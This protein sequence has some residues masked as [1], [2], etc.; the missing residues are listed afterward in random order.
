[1]HRL[2]DEPTG[3]GTVVRQQVGSRLAQDVSAPTMPVPGRG[4]TDRSSIGYRCRWTQDEQCQ[5]QE[6]FCLNRHT[7]RSN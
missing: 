5:K 3:H 6:P 1:M 7:F 4:C 2:F